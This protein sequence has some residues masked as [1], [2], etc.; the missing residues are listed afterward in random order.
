MTE[1]S[2]NGGK[3]RSTNGFNINDAKDWKAPAPVEPPIIPPKKPDPVVPEPPVVTPPA[4]DWGEKNNVLLNKLV[5]M[6]QWIIDK[7]KGVF[8]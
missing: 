6:V 5:E 1:Y 2:Y 7:L 8:K 4:T 3:I